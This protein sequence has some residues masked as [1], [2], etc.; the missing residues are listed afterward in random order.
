MIYLDNAATTKIAPEVLEAMMPYLTEEYGNAGSLY[1]LGRQAANA[2]EYARK[3]VADCIGAKPE[4]I[5]F[6]SGGTEANNLAIKGLAPYL[7]SKNKTHIITTKVEHDSVLNTIEEMN[8]KHGF[9]I[10]YL[11]VSPDGSVPCGLAE[12]LSQTITENTGLVSLMYVNNELGSVTNI[13]KIS[14]ICHEYGILLHTDC[15]Q[16]LGTIRIDV[17]ELDC[18]FLSISSHKIHG[19]KGVGALYVKNQSLLNS[20]ITGGT[21]QEF[22]LRGGTEN[23][24]GIVGFGKACELMHN[25]FKE[26]N[27]NI[28]YLKTLFLHVLSGTLNT[29]Y[30]LTNVISL[31]TKHYQ[32]TG[33]ILSVRVKDIDAQTLVLYLDTK[34]VCISA[35]SACRSH[36]S[37]PSRTL[38]AIGLTPEEARSTV[39]IS[40]SHYLTAEQVFEAAKTMALAIKVLSGEQNE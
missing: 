31:N 3:Q 12:T 30:G 27:G 10:S 37:E 1:S 7:K 24:P 9:D 28:S 4:Q 18:D 11:E 26:I 21:E 36:E 8:I 39:R 35:G 33:K 22:G 23:V 16:A 25:S 34:G 40:F 13:N 6:T 20:L 14:E 15:V 5:I 38:I 32:N 2:V 29:E 19:A 17:N